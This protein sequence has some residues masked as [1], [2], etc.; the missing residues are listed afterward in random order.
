MNTYLYT[1]SGADSYLSKDAISYNMFRS[2]LKNIALSSFFKYNN[3]FKTLNIPKEEMDALKALSN[4]KSIVILKPNKG[5]GVVILDKTDYVN[6]MNNILDN[7][8]KFQ[9]ISDVNGYDIARNLEQ[10]LR[11]YLLAIKKKGV[12]SQEVY[13]KLYPNGSTVCMIYGLPKI[14]KENLPLRPVLSAIGTHNY[15]LAKYLTDIITPVSNSKN[16]YSAK[17]T[18]DFISRISKA[19]I[20]NKYMVSFDVE[21]LFTNVPLDEVIGICAE[22][23]YHSNDYT[24]PKLPEE[25]FTNY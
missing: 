17:D 13:S 9:K 5:S 8:T 2:K 25:I 14:H 19:E 18:F 12:I 6:K 4:D 20:A 16:C 15:N 7:E 1:S 21:S 11:K 24:S 22:R 10:K 23:L 3:S